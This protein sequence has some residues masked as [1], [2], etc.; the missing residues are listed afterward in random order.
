MTQK[1]ELMAINSETEG[2]ETSCG[3]HANP[4]ADVDPNTNPDTDP[5]PESKK[6]C[7]I[8]IAT[9]IV[10]SEKCQ[11]CVIT[12][13][14]CCEQFKPGRNGGACYQC[15]RK[16]VRCVGRGGEWSFQ[17]VSLSEKVVGEVK[18]EPEVPK[19]EPKPHARAPRKK[20]TVEDQQGTSSGTGK[21]GEY[22]KFLSLSFTFLQGSMFITPCHEGTSTMC[23]NTQVN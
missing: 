20:K 15:S 2:K 11:K 23:Q 12:A 18:D 9:C 16:R 14:M 6:N 8:P 7:K 22:L 17:D 10:N 21:T 5:D 13:A 1:D 19:T 4:D 3:V